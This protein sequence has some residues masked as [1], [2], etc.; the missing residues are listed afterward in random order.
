MLIPCCR[1]NVVRELLS[2]DPAL[3][4]V[5]DDMKHTPLMIA[6]DRAYESPSP[7][8]ELIMQMLQQASTSGRASGSVDSTSSPPWQTAASE[9]SD[10][11]IH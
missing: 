10:Q 7:V 2:R 4:T 1:V 6:A 3:A 5:P 9:S 8:T 11:E